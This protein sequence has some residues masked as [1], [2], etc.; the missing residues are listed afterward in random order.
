MDFSSSLRGH[1]KLVRP[2]HMRVLGNGRLTWVL[3][4]GG[5]S[6]ISERGRPA[7]PASRG[8]R[9]SRS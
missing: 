8:S 4:F 3:S 7:R 9:R 2:F 6:L 5:H 1:V